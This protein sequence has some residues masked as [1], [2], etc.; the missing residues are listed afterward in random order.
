[1]FGNLQWALTMHKEIQ[2][3]VYQLVC[4]RLI[5]LLKNYVNNS[6]T[7]IWYPIIY[8]CT[9]VLNGHCTCFILF[10]VQ[11]LRFAVSYVKQPLSWSSSDVRGRF[12]CDSLRPIQERLTAGSWDVWKSF[13]VC[14]SLIR[15]LMH[16][17]GSV[18][19]KIGRDV[20]FFPPLLSRPLVRKTC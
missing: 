20:G 13:I 14:D 8:S 16:W 18:S 12:V 9:N 6:V 17:I 7:A 10:I 11:S 2:F 5:A 1:M 19:S 15:C 3:G 4:V